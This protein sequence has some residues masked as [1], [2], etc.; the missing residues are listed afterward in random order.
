MKSEEII[1]R[2][3][4]NQLISHAKF[5]TPLEVVSWLG[6]I[7]AQDYDGAK[8]S[9]GA[10]IPEI[11][12]RDVE[13]AIADKAFVRTWM[14]RGTLH[15]V[16]AA[17][18][19]WMLEL[20]TPQ[21]IARSAAHY[22]QLELDDNVFTRSKELFYREL[23]NCKQL[24]RDEMYSLLEKANISTAGQRGYHI[25]RRA[26]QDGLIFFG[27]QIGKRE[28]FV[29]LDEWAPGAKRMERDLAL[30]ELALRYFTSHGPATVNDFAWWS[31][32]QVSDAKV[33]LEAISSR[34][35]SEKING[36]IY[37]I[38]SNSNDIPEISSKVYLL[39]GYDEYLL[40]YKDRIAVLDEQYA[41]KICPGRNGVF[42]P[43][44]V[45]NGRIAGTWKAVVKKSTLMV[46]PQSFVSFTELEECEFFEAA[47]R[48]GRFLEKPI[49]FK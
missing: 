37:Y 45:I 9:I 43:T 41:E 8:W 28:T 1:Q 4:S 11:T 12:D 22:R 30:V 38:S 2:R 34:L 3:I 13:Q 47:K 5:K 27:P 26:A 20:L 21:V 32:L 36:Q 31:A 42:N 17:D 40:G 18:I 7:Q 44:I 35:I 39:P 25:L 46:I 15:F 23:E 33:G 14:M 6:A 48:Y 16:A 19:R 10:R 29:L 24:T 49:A